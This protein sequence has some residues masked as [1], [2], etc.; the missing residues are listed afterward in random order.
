[1]DRLPRRAAEIIIVICIGL[2]GTL[3]PKRAW[4]EDAGTPPADAGAP[5]DA[6]QTPE[7]APPEIIESAEAAYPEQARSERL[8]GTV[9]LQL[10]IDVEGHVTEAEVIEPAGHGF[11]EAAREAAL[12]FRFAP[13]RRN[14]QPV[15]SRIRYPVLFKLEPEAPPAPA[16]GTIAGRLTMDGTAIAGA[17]VTLTGPEGRTS[18]VTTDAE[19]RFRASDLSP[20]P[21]QARAVRNSRTAT[22]TIDVA[23]AA[24]AALEL[25][26]AP[27]PA[28]VRPIAEQ[29][30]EV[31]VR[32]ALSEAQRLQQ[33]A[34]AVNV[35]DTRRAQKESA[36]LGEVLARQAGVTFRRSGGLGSDSRFCLNGSC[37]DAIRFFVDGVPL[38]L[39]GY[40]SGGALGLSITP[41]NFIERVEI[42]RGVVPIRFGADALGGAV[43]LV[44]D[45]SYRPGLVASYQVGSFGIHRTTVSARYRHGPSGF[46]ASGM[47]LFDD[48]QNDYFVDVEIPDERGRLQP[49]TVR[50]FHDAFQAYGASLGAG[51]IEKP[52]ARRL[53]LQGFASTYDKELQ[54]NLVMTVP[55]G[56]VTYGETVYG[57][58]ARYDVALHRAVDLELVANYAHRIIDYE[59]QGRWVYDW[60]GQRIRE[61]RVAG[62]I[63]SRPRDQTVWQDGGFGRALLKWAIAPE[64]ILRLSLSPM[65]TTRT[66]DER[67]QADPN[68]RDPL[69]AK[70]DLLTFVSGLE[71]ELNL[72]GER[73]S[74]IVFVKDYFYR[75]DSE[76][77]LPGGIFRERQTESHTQG[78]G[79]SLRFRFT[80]WLYA[81]A[82]YEFATRLPRPDEVFGNGVLV[83]ANLELEPE[84]SHNAN[85]GPRVELR[86]TR[87]GD[88][89]I[90]VNAFLR[91]SDRL[92]V[93]LGNDR[94]FSYQNVYKARGLGLENALA[95]VSPGR[96]VSLDGTLTWQDVRNVSDEGTFGDFAGDRIPNRPYLFGS[97]GVRLRFPNLPG[98][99]DTLEP[100]YIGRY[101][102][103]F[104]RGWESQGLREFKQVVDAQVT[105]NLGVTWTMS[106][107]FARVSSTFEVSNVTDAKVFDNFGVQ[108]PGRA[109]FLKLTGEI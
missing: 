29:P 97:W 33:S 22:G 1:V 98:Q 74:N 21:Y 109:F 95:W 25:T 70:R 5:P 52:W 73:L 17:D 71:Y 16:T 54:H 89:T 60:N 100:F 63:E 34:E 10:S 85:L 78:V 68:A 4:A 58:T 62:E 51:V 11:D 12:R 87:I 94:F 6:Q 107:D 104:F 15:P 50:R 83:L 88:L 66:G 38:E 90:D 106:R 23:A 31:T 41:V 44:T 8:E 2:L 47:A 80:P 24:E 39:A 19:G 27:L 99:N 37:D 28:P 57:G 91:E 76:E 75:A 20:G 79:D 32:G 93:L 92:I 55:Y 26:F 72:F 77:P 46:V 53:L 64:H 14:G 7:L 9:V 43:N 103:E 36:D 49:A 18:T 56:E 61:R 30:V 108:R 42:Y 13:A 81:K 59:D 84:V 3:V 65:Y 35:V 96:W 45:Q 69:T 101:V 86:R 82:S 67:I 48:A 105:H 102:H 40:P